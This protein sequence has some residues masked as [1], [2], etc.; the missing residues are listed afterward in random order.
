MATSVLP[1]MS[2]TWYN[3]TSNVTW[4]DYQNNNTQKTDSWT[5]NILPELLA[6]FLP[7]ILFAVPANL[8]II[9][10]ILCNK[11][12]R[13]QTFFLGILSISAFD[14]IYCVF[15]LPINID[16]YVTWGRWRH[17]NV[18][19]FIYI[20][21]IN[22]KIYTT[23]LMITA[24][25]AERLL[26]KLRSVA[27][28]SDRMTRI[29]SK[30]MVAMPWCFFVLFTVLCVLIKHDEMTRE[31]YLHETYCLFMAE[32]TF[33]MP[34]VV[35]AF[36]IP[37]CL[38]VLGPVVMIVMYKCK[39][40]DW[41]RLSSGTQETESLFMSTLC[42]W[43][44]SFV[45]LVFCTPMTVCMT[46]I[47]LCIRNR[48]TRCPTI[49]F[50]KNAYTVS[51]LPCAIMP[52]LWILTLEIRAILAPLK[53]RARKLVATPDGTRITLSSLRHRVSA[54]DKEILH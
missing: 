14:L 25:S 36:H 16:H 22:S 15:A 50:Y 10:I 2:T 4:P 44:V 29:L 54:D 28:V 3:T 31:N 53:E 43:I 34:Y 42:V 33:H 30:V 7:T 26:T 21:L 24:L 35:V 23:A 49:N 20:I 39:K 1:S 17:G 32:Q 11:N 19:C 47:I 37:L 27:V 38:L 5:S 51:L 48:S 8:T 13:T 9:I 12:L 52:Y 18:I 40:S 45:Y 46:E 6:R 41:D